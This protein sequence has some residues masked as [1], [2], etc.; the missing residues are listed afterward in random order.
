MWQKVTKFKGA[1][2]FRKALYMQIAII[3]TEAADLVKIN[4]CVILKTFGHDCTYLPQLSRTPA[5]R[6][7]TG[8]PCTVV[9]KSFE[10]DTNIH[11]HKVC[12]LSLYDG[13]LHILQNVMKSDQIN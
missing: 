7:G 4:I 5:H 10:N 12:Y 2:Y 1:E 9:V 6:L 8:T 11:F 13:N 3:Q